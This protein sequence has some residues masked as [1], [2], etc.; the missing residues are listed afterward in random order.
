ML[1]F[2]RLRG[3]EA[4]FYR[5]QAGIVFSDSCFFVPKNLAAL[6]AEVA[7]RDSFCRILSDSGR[8]LVSLDLMA[9][10]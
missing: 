9:V 8:M 5:W 7:G 10:S 2:F 3:S 6:L 1:G 4:C